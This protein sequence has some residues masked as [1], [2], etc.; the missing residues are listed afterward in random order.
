MLTDIVTYLSIAG[1]I[2]GAF[3]GCFNTPKAKR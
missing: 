3:W 1:V 2:I